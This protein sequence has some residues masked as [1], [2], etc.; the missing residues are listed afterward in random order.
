MPT[1]NEI[2]E[3]LIVARDIL[4]CGDVDLAIALPGK[5]GF[6]SRLVSV[7]AP[8][9]LMESGRAEVLVIVVTPE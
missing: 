3:K 1:V 8:T 6:T 5:D 9:V 2:I 4:K 7:M